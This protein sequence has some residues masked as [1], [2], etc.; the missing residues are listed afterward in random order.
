MCKKS[1]AVHPIINFLACFV[2]MS[3]LININK[4]NANLKK[5]VWRNFSKFPDG[6]WM[7]QNEKAKKEH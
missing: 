3:T 4:E 6:I 2:Y 5:L 7:K 1:S